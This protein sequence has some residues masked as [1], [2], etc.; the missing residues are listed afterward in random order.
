MNLKTKYEIG[1]RLWP[2]LNLNSK[3]FVAR[4]FDCQFI[5]Y[6]GR[7]LC[8]CYT[9]EYGFPEFNVFANEADAK[10]ACESRNY[11]VPAKSSTGAK[12]R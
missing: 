7:E 5:V 9:R 3:A 1:D 6:D 4:P 11:P 10:I 12:K 2:V 8:Y